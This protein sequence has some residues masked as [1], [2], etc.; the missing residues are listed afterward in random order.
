MDKQNPE[1]NNEAEI[2]KAVLNQLNEHTV[3]GFALFY[4][5]AESGFPTQILNFDSPAHCLAMQKY[6][7]DWSNALQAIYIEGAKE[8][9]KQALSNESEGE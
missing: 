8:N 5:N 4:F 1:A 3:G 9:I 7:F 6:M 2:P